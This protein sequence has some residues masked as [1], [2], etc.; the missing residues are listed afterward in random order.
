MASATLKTLLNSKAGPS[1]SI[2]AL[3]E[4]L[5]GGV[6]IEDAE[7]K[8]L[9]GVLSAGPCRAPISLDGR[10]L[11]WVT[12]PPAAAGAVAS[13]LTHLA[14]KES[15]RRALSTEVLHLYREVHLIEQLS[16]QLTALLDLSSVSQSAL[17][18]ARRLIAASHGG[19]LVMEK[20]GASLR[21]V[22]S[23]GADVPDLSA[24]S[25]F[26]A[27]IVQRGVAEIVNDCASDPRALEA[28]PSLRSLI[29]AP[30]RAK[31]RTVGVIAL[32]NSSGAPYSSTDLKLLN[33]IALQTAAAIENSILCSEMVG[34]VRDREQ[35]AAIQ[36]ELDTART[37]QH[38]LV[39]RTFPPFPERTDF[40][41][42]AQMTSAKAVGGDFFDFFL[43]DDDHLGVVIGDVSG[44]GIPAALY[45]AVTRT[46]IKT[47][48]LEGLAPEA[49]LQEVNRVLV[50]ERVSS[51]FATCFY[52]LISIRTGELRYCNA[53]HNPP[54]LLR[55][56]G[57]VEPLD[58]VG[59]MPLGL[60]ERKPYEG[61]LVQ[62]APGDALFL[63]TDGVPEATNVALDDF[64]DERL[65]AILLG[66]NSLSCRD[67]VDRVA[68]E[69]LDFTAGAPQSDDITMLT[70]RLTG[71]MSR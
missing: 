28:E 61:G 42:H 47:T 68:R 38:S 58:A 10:T 33:T 52:G 7:G 26:A 66:A 40:D 27:A 65:A 4:A 57:A 9:L 62:L 51:M 21:S 30:L 14:A 67:I 1:S 46:Q 43:I 13:L 17:D 56:S 23:F 12:G 11:G 37:I 20:P 6:G 19:I 8:A 59:G 25:R 32:A 31:Q 35:L 16:E 50:R 64:T 3:V 71:A 2:A 29:C 36:K 39:P 48:A 15:E 34:A 44:K 41:I 69:V 49:C 45:M 54:H 53:G 18:Q 55:T 60:F 24:A 70:I 63:Y 22:I 5:G